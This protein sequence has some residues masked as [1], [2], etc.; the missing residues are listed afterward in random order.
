M[1]LFVIALICHWPLAKNS[2][3]TNKICIATHGGF[4]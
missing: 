4:S 2:H 3:G 1:L